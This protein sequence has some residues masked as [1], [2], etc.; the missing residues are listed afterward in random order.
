MADYA[1]DLLQ[2]FY[3]LLM[4]SQYWPPA[5]MREYQE[6]QLGH[7]LR[8]ARANS[9]FYATRLDA[10]FR[11]DGS[12]D[13]SRW[14]QIPIL[15]RQDLVDHREAM[16][17]NNV[18]PHHGP[19]GD[20]STSGSTGIPVTVR[21]NGM[22]TLAGRAAEYR[23]FDWHKIDFSQVVCRIVS[24]LD[25]PR[26]PE[27]RHGGPWG[28][29]WAYGTSAGRTALIGMFERS[30]HILEFIQRSEAL[31][32]IANSTTA[33]ALALE[34]ERLGS[35]LRFDRLFSAGSTP[36]A[37]ERE[38]LAR[39]FRASLLQRYASKEANAIAHSCP[40]GDGFHVHGENTLVEVLGADGEPCEPGETGSVVVTP[41]LSTHQP[42]IRYE[43]GDLA[44][45]GG[46]C[47]CGRSLPVL[48]EVAG[49]I[50]HI[51]RFPD[52]TSTFRR[53]PES[54]RSQL[55]ARAW[56]VAQVAPLWIELRYESVNP[57]ERGDEDA[58]LDV[59]RLLYPADAKLSVRRVA[60]I[61]LTA[62]GKYLEYVREVE[63]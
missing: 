6:E 9:P 23:A 35:S 26:W 28:P 50:R 1:S 61:P 8:H 33:H 4:E 32:L 37:P 46:P 7:L 21:T 17:A 24:D 58:A 36:T 38:A 39:V 52:G 59:M 63:D 5:R 13:F 16:L 43:Q 30:E 45:V 34:A 22:A 20:F 3:D 44:T 53:L 29:P 2:Q 18:P 31:Y 40:A 27:G 10:V 15:K 12:I 51:F 11:R 57:V 54:L 41:F 48:T 19:G 14:R 56:Q 62:S 49:R 25:V 60:R 42:L 47:N 55:K